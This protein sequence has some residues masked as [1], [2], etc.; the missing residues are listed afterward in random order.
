MPDGV[1][2]E[3]LATGTTLAA[4]SISFEAVPGLRASRS[5]NSSAAEKLI[6]RYERQLAVEQDKDKPTP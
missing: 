4:K 1:E 2:V 5:W 3:R 6:D